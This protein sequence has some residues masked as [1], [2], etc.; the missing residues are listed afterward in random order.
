EVTAIRLSAAESLLKGTW[1]HQDKVRGV[2]YY[3]PSVIPHGSEYWYYDQRSFVLPYLSRR[4]GSDTVSMQLIY[5][6]AGSSW[7]FFEDITVVADDERFTDS[8]SYYSVTRDVSGGTVC[9]TAETSV[10]YDSYYYKMLK[11]MVDADDVIVRFEGD[12]YYRDITISRSDKNA[13]KK[14]LDAY[15]AFHTL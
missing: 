2:T 13:I 14:I 12:D 9:E 4:D 3:Y 8:F 1:K 6:Y 7:V 10:S 5:C 11:A 15:D